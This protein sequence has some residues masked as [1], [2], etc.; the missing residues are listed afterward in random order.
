LSE[1]IKTKG[2]V[3]KEQDY[4][5]QDTI[6]TIFTEEKGIISCIAKGSRKSKSKLLS[7]TQ[8]FSYSAFII[9]FKENNLSIINDGDLLESFYDIRNNLT[10]ISYASYLSEC[11][12]KC[13]QHNTK[14]TKILYTLI[15][16]LFYLSSRPQNNYWWL[17]LAFQLK[18]VTYMGYQP[19]FQLCHSCNSISDKMFF[20][21]ENGELVCNK[22][23]EENSIIANQCFIISTNEIKFLLTLLKQPIK[24][25]VNILIDCEYND[26][27]YLL[28]MNQYIENQFDTR[29][30]SFFFISNY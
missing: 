26:S 6:L 14:E 2:L 28:M 30:N 13:I 27:K 25:S 21:P 1:I 18:L 16:V 15:N 4:L 5:E 24:Q 11:C 8:L 17:I 7:S 20:N 3:L 23:I 22:C 12:R 10:T 29:I 19:D 9:Y